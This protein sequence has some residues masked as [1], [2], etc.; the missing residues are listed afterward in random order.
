MMVF[1]EANSFSRLTGGIG[2]DGGG[3]GG[4]NAPRQLFDDS[5][6]LSYSPFARASS[7]HLP[8]GS[9]RHQNSVKHLSNMYEYINAENR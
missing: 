7:H 9:S 2:G 4:W 3:T 5:G 8:Q 6:T 1:C